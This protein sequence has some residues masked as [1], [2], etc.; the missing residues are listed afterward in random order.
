M[1]AQARVF[2]RTPSKKV[3][4]FVPAQSWFVDLTLVSLQ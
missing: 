1:K 2:R 3:Q 4:G